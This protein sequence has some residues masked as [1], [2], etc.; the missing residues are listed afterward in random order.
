MNDTLVRAWLLHRRSYRDSSALVDLLLVGRGLTRAVARG[1]FS[2]KSRLAQTLQPFCPLAVSLG[3]HGELATLIKAETDGPPLLLKGE[4]L[5]CGFYLNELLVRLL[6][7]DD[8]CDALLAAYA[9]ALAWLER[10]PGQAQQALRPFEQVLLAH[11]GYELDWRHDGHGVPVVADLLY[12]FVPAEGWLAG[13]RPGRAV[14][15]ASL[16][17]LAQPA[18]E[19]WFAAARAVFRAMLDALLGGKPL[20]SRALLLHQRKRMKE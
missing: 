9:E 16:L 11:L 7:P 1:V 4:A 5:L 12:H 8:E 6:G 3:G 18:N 15:G 2:G 17:A 20:Q 19:A 13:G 10:S 14:P